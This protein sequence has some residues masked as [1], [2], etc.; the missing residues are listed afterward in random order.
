MVRTSIIK[1]TRIALAGLLLLPLGT[2]AAGLGKL[3][4]LSGLGQPL[5]AEIEVVAV[6]RAEAETLAARIAAPEAFRE[7]GVDYGAVIPQM[8]AAL[9]RRPDNRYVITLTTPQPVEEPFL[10]VLVELNWAA[11]RLVRQYTFLLDPAEYK[12]PQAITVPPKVAAP[13]VQPVAPPKPPAVTGGAGP[14]AS[15]SRQGACRGRRRHVR[16][17]AGRHAR[18]DRRGQ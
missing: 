17:K 15:R 13:E 12:G 7:A 5:R 18:Q 11:G 8:R 3:T 4:V 1:T 2:M 6:Q 14:G 9:Q 10:D 16:S